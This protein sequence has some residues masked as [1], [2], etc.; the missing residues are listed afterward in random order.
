MLLRKAVLK[1]C[2]KFTGEHQ[3]GSVI[4]IKLQGNFIEI[5]LWHGCSPVNL[6]CCMFLF[7]GQKSLFLIGRLLGVEIDWL[8]SYDIYE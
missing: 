3:C 2:S 4:S 6:L 1:I 5:A 8:I 7:L